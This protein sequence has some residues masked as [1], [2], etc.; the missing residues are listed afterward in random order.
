[1]GFAVQLVVPNGKVPPVDCSLE[2]SRAGVRLTRGDTGAEQLFQFSFKQIKGWSLPKPGRVLLQALRS[3][4]KYGE[5]TIQARGP[6]PNAL[7]QEIVRTLNTTAQGLL[8]ERKTT[9]APTGELKGAKDPPAAAGPSASSTAAKKPSSHP[10]MKAPAPPASKPGPPAGAKPSPTASKGASDLSPPVTRP[11]GYASAPAPQIRTGPGTAPT[12]R[13]RMSNLNQPPPPPAPTPSSTPSPGSGRDDDSRPKVGSVSAMRESLGRNPSVSSASSSELEAAQRRIKELEMGQDTQKRLEQELAKMKEELKEKQQATSKLHSRLSE[14]TMRD[15]T[16]LETTKQELQTAK[17][18]LQTAN[19]ELQTANQELKTANQESTEMAQALEAAEDERDQ[20]EDNMVGETVRLKAELAEAQAGLERLQEEMKQESENQQAEVKQAQAQLEQAETA[21]TEAQADGSSQDEI[22][23]LQRE[24]EAAKR[25][26]K[27]SEVEKTKKEAEVVRLKLELRDTSTLLDKAALQDKEH[28]QSL[29]EMHDEL[30]AKN[31][32]QQELEAKLSMEQGQSQGVDDLQEALKTKESRERELED[33]LAAERRVAREARERASRMESEAEDAKTQLEAKASSG[34]QSESEAKRLASELAEQKNMARQLKLEAAEA[35]EKMEGLASKMKEAAEELD[36]TAAERDAQATQVLQLRASLEQEK[37]VAAQQRAAAE[38]ERATT[39]QL[40]ASVGN[41]HAKILQLIQDLEA[42]KVKSAQLQAQADAAK[43]QELQLQASLQAKNQAQEKLQLL[44]EDANQQVLAKQTSFH[45][46]IEAAKSGSELAEAAALKWKKVALHAQQNEKELETEVQELTSAL[47]LATNTCL[48]DNLTTEA[49]LREQE[50]TEKMLEQARREITALEQQTA[51]KEDH[52]KDLSM[53]LDDTKSSALA[54]KQSDDAELERLRKE[55]SELRQK[56]ASA[57]EEVERLKKMAPPASAGPSSGDMEITRALDD[58]QGEREKVKRG[59]KEL[60]ELKM[61]VAELEDE[62]KAEVSIREDLEESIQTG[63]GMPQIR[64]TRSV[65]KFEKYD[66]K[67]DK[68]VGELQ[69]AV[70]DGEGGLPEEVARQQIARLE[71]QLTIH[72]EKLEAVQRSADEMIEKI[73]LE[74]VEQVQRVA[75]TQDE[76]ERLQNRLKSGYFVDD[77]EDVP[78]DVIEVESIE[79]AKGMLGRSMKRLR[80]EIRRREEAETESQQLQDLLTAAREAKLKLVDKLDKTEEQ[81]HKNEERALKLG[82]QLDARSRLREREDLADFGGSRFFGNFQVEGLST[83]LVGTQ[84]QTEESRVSQL[85]PSLSKKGFL[86]ISAN[87]IQVVTADLT[88]RDVEEYVEGSEVLINF[89]LGSVVGWTVNRQQLLF[90]VMREDSGREEVCV[91]ISPNMRGPVIGAM[92]R[93][94]EHESNEAVI[95]SPHL[96]HV[97][98][99]SVVKIDGATRRRARDQQEVVP[100]LEDVAEALGSVQARLEQRLMMEARHSAPQEVREEMALVRQEL[101][102]VKA[103]RLFYHKGC[104]ELKK[105]KVQLKQELANL[106]EEYDDLQAEHTAQKVLTTKLKKERD[107]HMADLKGCQKRATRLELEVQKLHEAPSGPGEKEVYRLQDEIVAMEETQADLEAKLRGA[108]HE[109]TRQKMEMA[110]LRTECANLKVECQRLSEIASQAISA[111]MHKQLESE[112]GGSD[113]QDMSSAP[114]GTQAAASQAQDMSTSMTPCT[115]FSESS[116]SLLMDPKSTSRMAH[117]QDMSTSRSPRGSVITWKGLDTRDIGTDITRRGSM[118]SIVEVDSDDSQDEKGVDNELLYFKLRVNELEEQLRKKEKVHT[119]TNS[120]GMAN[121]EA[122]VQRL[123][124]QVDVEKAKLEAEKIRFD[125]E[126]MK[127]EAQRVKQDSVAH[128]LVAPLETEKAQLVAEKGKLETGVQLM[129]SEMKRLKADVQKMTVERSQIDDDCKRLEEE[130]KR[131]VEDLQS[132][133][134]RLEFRE[135]V[136][137]GLQEELEQMKQAQA[138]VDEATGKRETE[139]EKL[140]EEQRLEREGSKKLEKE[141]ERLQQQLAEERNYALQQREMLEAQ[142]KRAARGLE[143]LELYRKYAEE[144]VLAL[145]EEKTE[146]RMQLDMATGKEQEILQERIAMLEGLLERQRI[147]ENDRI[148]E[149]KAEKDDI[150]RQL[151]MAIGLATHQENESIATLQLDKQALQERVAS[152]SNDLYNANRRADE[153]VQAVAS[154]KFDATK[155]LDDQLSSAMDERRKLQESLTKLSEEQ[156]NL[157]RQSAERL[158][159]LMAE[160]RGLQERLTGLSARHFEVQTR[161]DKVVSEAGADK[162]ALQA[163]LDDTLERLRKEGEEHAKMLDTAVTRQYRQAEQR[164]KEVQA[165]SLALQRQLELQA[166]T[167]ETKA[168]HQLSALRAEVRDMIQQMADMSSEKFQ[169]QQELEAQLSDQAEIRMGLQQQLEDLRAASAMHK[170]DREQLEAEKLF[171]ETE[172]ADLQAQ[173]SREKIKAQEQVE[174][175]INRQKRYADAVAE[176]LTAALERQQREAASRIAFVNEEKYDLQQQIAD[177][178][179]VSDD[180]SAAGRRS[181]IFQGDQRAQTLLEEMSALSS[182]KY[183]LQTK[184]ESMVAALNTEKLELQRHVESL[185]AANAMEVGD[186]QAGVAEQVAKLQE[187]EAERLEL[188]E[189]AQQAETALQQSQ[190]EH[191]QEMARQRQSG[192]ER[193]MTLQES[194][195][196]QQAMLDERLQTLRDENE[197]LRAQLRAVIERSTEFTDRQVSDLQRDKAEMLQQMEDMSLK[198]FEQQ[199]ELEERL[200]ALSSEKYNLTNQISE[201][202]VR[203]GRRSTV[204][205]GHIMQSVRRQTLA[206]GQPP[207]LQPLQDPT[208]SKAGL[209]GPDE[210]ISLRAKISGSSQRRESHPL[211]AVCF[212]GGCRQASERA[213]ET[214]ELS[215]KNAEDMA[216]AAEARIVATAEQLQQVKAL[217]EAAAP[218]KDAQQWQ[219]MQQLAKLQDQLQE[220]RGLVVQEKQKK[221]EHDLQQLEQVQQLQRNLEA[222]R[223]EVKRLDAL[224]ID[225]AAEVREKDALM[226][227]RGSRGELELQQMQHIKQLHKDLEKERGEV[228]R[229][230]AQALQLEGQLQLMRQTEAAQKRVMEEQEREQEQLQEQRDELELEVQQQRNLAEGQRLTGQADLVSHEAALQA[231][232]EER[233]AALKSG[234]LEHESNLKSDF[235]EREAVLRA[236]YAQREAALVA[237][238]EQ[239]EAALQ[240]HLEQLDSDFFEKAIESTNEKSAVKAMEAGRWQAEQARQVLEEEKMQA[241]GEMRTLEQQKMQLEEERW[242]VMQEKRAVEEHL[243]QLMEDK[244]KAETVYRQQAKELESKNEELRAQNVE[245]GIAE[246]KANTSLRG[247]LQELQLL[248]RENSAMAGRMKELGVSEDDLTMIRQ[249]SSSSSKPQPSVAT[250]SPEGAEFF[251]PRASLALPPTSTG[252]DYPAAS[253]GPPPRPRPGHS[254]EGVSPPLSAAASAGAGSPLSGGTEGARPGTEMLD[255]LRGQVDSVLSTLTTSS[256]STKPHAAAPPKTPKVEQP[257]ASPAHSPMPFGTSMGSMYSAPTGY[258]SIAQPARTF[259]PAPRPDMLSSTSF[260]DNGHGAMEERV[261][262]A[263]AADGVQQRQRA[264]LTELSFMRQELQATQKTEQKK[265]TA[266][267]EFSGTP[268]VAAAATPRSSHKQLLGV[269]DGILEIVQER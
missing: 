65:S 204:L 33:M 258:G 219:L 104:S 182:E 232:Y 162:R 181:S 156:F 177:N 67:M 40:Q 240:R 161:L 29:K 30:R 143:E 66:A 269:I 82:V 193:A 54:A 20:I 101:E 124:A 154:E 215:A 126:M 179:F 7:A 257:V 49:K 108:D 197:E 242:Q 227:E 263:A 34:D 266:H 220:E 187:I 85:P 69:L 121:L 144:R 118:A 1:M 24:L 23:A 205:Q 233:E 117:L 53:Q 147:V 14:S 137:A 142:E 119:D 184:L 216:K 213:V 12:Q 254:E 200:A 81:S 202:M 41:E 211:R 150:K 132:E 74:N 170:F 134:S 6:N 80:R 190:E 122:E 222:E 27:E 84:I 192:E 259:S 249:L 107:E 5:I 98:F 237:D 95:D 176:Q 21:L 55:N 112:A 115:S 75:E 171:V 15:T 199:Q 241:V 62:L 130:K 57:E 248:E 17:Q 125:A 261:E 32:R 260:S 11:S 250:T 253:S 186:L 123:M 214:A 26:L 13:S 255:V 138:A 180:A 159:Q 18:E 94:F 149:I 73:T 8:Q 265:Y 127:V 236:D 99:D 83:A 208:K 110:R 152:L 185:Q 201:Q 158:D 268:H 43:F 2:V 109:S 48:E 39:A 116:G 50:E 140:E 22:S 223:A 194:M 58:L 76:L 178:I 37:E 100:G 86:Q 224:R 218:E 244:I 44:L 131:L 89:T 96:L 92:M 42:E 217:Q 183:D 169:M 267:V 206:G 239:R 167:Q 198:K 191:D 19:Q 4:G 139:Q 166:E 91:S 164:V 59:D 196:R 97:T 103:E 87:S 79:Q 210:A 106:S 114:A 175:A 231:G 9:S 226:A 3:E 129:T 111:S 262:K 64:G 212:P 128:Q 51:E 63:E 68:E 25:Q 203:M 145:T 221:V 90:H 120:T 160:K 234:F 72:R 28:S 238:S 46:E 102:A 10:P 35:K 256:L 189:R 31:E 230:D 146:L 174:T 88:G 113:Q 229:L 38:G 47:E 155:R 93:A 195:E 77:D 157:Q 78:E 45:K 247:A 36:Q 173:L 135:K 153:R 243:N 71:H 209:Q 163:Q 264:L 228:R 141:L 52:I 245:R 136:I 188:E 105:D 148:A 70:T 16:Q 172:K 251:T 60:F 61:R 56:L 252:T 133:V 246:A 207:A 225:L 151:D 168:D 165:E 235:E